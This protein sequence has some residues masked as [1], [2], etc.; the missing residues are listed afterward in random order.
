MICGSKGTTKTSGLS[1]LATL[2]LK[3]RKKSDLTCFL[4]ADELANTVFMVAAFQP[5]QILI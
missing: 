1:E 4:H 5:E 2:E 3:N